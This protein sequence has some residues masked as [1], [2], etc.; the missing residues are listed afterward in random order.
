MYG[1][2]AWAWFDLAAVAVAA[3][4][5]IL[6][7]EASAAAA[8]LCSGK[9]ARAAPGDSS[10]WLLA[11]MVIG[12]FELSTRRI[13]GARLVTEGVIHLNA[14]LCAVILLTA[15]PVPDHQRQVAA[16]QSPPARWH[17]LVAM[18]LAA[19]LIATIWP[20]G[21]S[22]RGVYGDR[23]AGHAGHHIR[24]GPNATTSGPRNYH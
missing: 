7:A 20:T 4:L 12:N 2:S 21:R 8:R 1:I 5:A 14:L 6:M 23:F 13:Q 19:A 17:R 10:W 9:P 22:V 24:F 11:I 16:G 3:A 18:G 15:D